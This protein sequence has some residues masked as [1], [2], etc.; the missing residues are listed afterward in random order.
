MARDG[1]RCLMCGRS[2]D[3][4]PLQV[5]HVIAV[6]NG[7][8][9]E[10]ENLATLCSDCNAGKSAYRF[11]DY[12]A[13]GVIPQDLEQHFVHY[14]DDPIGDSVR[15]HLYLYYKDRTPGVLGDDKLH[16]TWQI[17]GSAFATSANP[18]AFQQ[19]RR[20]EEARVFEL[21]YAWRL[22]SRESASCKTRK[23]SAKLM[24]NP[25]LHAD[26]LQPP[27]AASARG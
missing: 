11:A 5:D 4:V 13:V 12:R 15:Y 18:T 9:D 2:K 8:T 3:D 26:A 21:K 20:E 7:G 22:C 10:L 19:R 23:G 1:Y 6:A 17:A 14:Q 27:S 16:H 24:A 25:S